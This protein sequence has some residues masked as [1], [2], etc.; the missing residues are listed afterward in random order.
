MIHIETTSVLAK[1]FLAFARISCLIAGITSPALYADE[2]NFSYHETI[3]RAWQLQFDAAIDSNGVIHLIAD[4]YY[5]FNLSGRQL[6]SEAQ[7]QEDR[8]SVV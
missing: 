4:Q 2:A 8:K 7:A 5:Q 3:I 6:T 1:C